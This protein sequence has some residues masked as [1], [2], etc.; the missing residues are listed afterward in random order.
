MSYVF[1]RNGGIGELCSDSRGLVSLMTK[2]RWLEI[3]SVEKK[4]KESRSPWFAKCLDKGSRT[5]R[6]YYK[7]RR[8]RRS[9]M[10]GKEEND[11]MVKSKKARR[12]F[13]PELA[14]PSG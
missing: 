8:H 6:K 7:L 12:E 4:R 14:E 1:E 5:I 13:E 9:A 2:H 3:S 10:Q 11:P